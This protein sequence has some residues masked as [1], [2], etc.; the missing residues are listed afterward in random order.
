MLWSDDDPVGWVQDRFVLLVPA[1]AI[2]LVRVVAEQ[3]DDLATSRRLAVQPACLDQIA[4]MCGV[5]V[6]DGIVTS[7][8]HSAAILASG[9]AAEPRAG[10]Y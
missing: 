7:F 10:I 9:S 4:Y 1:N 2:V 8:N 3:L 6:S 5:V